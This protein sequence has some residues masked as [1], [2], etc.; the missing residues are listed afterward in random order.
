MA[1]LCKIISIPDYPIQIHQNGD[2]RV[3]VSPRKYIKL[4]R[5]NSVELMD[6]LDSIS[7]TPSIL[8]L[9]SRESFSFSKESSLSMVLKAFVDGHHS[10]LCIL[11]DHFDTQDY[12]V[13]DQAISR[14]NRIFIGSDEDLSW[15]RSQL[16]AADYVIIDYSKLSQTDSL[17]QLLEFENKEKG[18]KVIGI[19]NKQ[20][21]VKTAL[22]FQSRWDGYGILPSLSTEKIKCEQ[23]SNVDLPMEG[24]CIHSQEKPV[25]VPIYDAFYQLNDMNFNQIKTVKDQPIQLT[26]IDPMHPVAKYAVA[27]A[28]NDGHAVSCVLGDFPT[29]VTQVLKTDNLSSYVLIHAQNVQNAEG[30]LTVCHGDVLRNPAPEKLCIISPLT[31]SQWRYLGFLK[32]QNPTLSL[33]VL[34]HVMVPSTIKVQ[35]TMMINAEDRVTASDSLSLT[36]DKL[37]STPEFIASLC[38]SNHTIWIQGQHPH[39]ST[40]IATHIEED[41]Q[42]I[43]RCIIHPNDTLQDLLG[44]VVELDITMDVDVKT[45]AKANGKTSLQLP[46]KTRLVYQPS[47]WSQILQDPQATLIIE[48]LDHNPLLKTALEALCVTRSF[49]QNGCSV[50]VRARLI[51]LSEKK[52]DFFSGPCVSMNSN[53]D[54]V[55]RMSAL[56][57]SIR[58]CHQHEKTEAINE[59][60]NRDVM[61]EIHGASGTGKRETL[62]HCMEDY[63][64][65]TPY[66]QLR[67]ISCSPALDRQTVEETLLQWIHCQTPCTVVIDRYDVMALGYWR[68]LIPNQNREIYIQ[69]QIYQ[70]P[71]THRC[72]FVSQDHPS[73]T[74]SNHTLCRYIPTVTF[75]IYPDSEIVSCVR[76]LSED[77]VIVDWYLSIYTVCQ[78]ALNKPLSFLEISELW[79]WH[80]FYGQTMADETARVCALYNLLSLRYHQKDLCLLKQLLPVS[81][82]CWDYV[83]Q[84]STAQECTDRS[85]F[86]T[87]D[88]QKIRTILTAH[89]SPSLSDQPVKKHPIV[90]IQGEAGCGKDY[91]VDSVLK[92]LG[93]S[94]HRVKGSNLQAVLSS[95]KEA[96]A[97]NMI[98]VIEEADLMP[99]DMIE[100]LIDPLTDP[101]HFSIIATV[102][103]IHYDGRQPISNGILAQSLVIQCHP[104][105]D[106]DLRGML[107]QQFGHQL[108]V[109]Q[110]DELV[111]LYRAVSIPVSPRE[112]FRIVRDFL[113]ADQLTL[114]E[115][116]DQVIMTF[117][118]FRTPLSSYQKS[119][120]QVSEILKQKILA[121]QSLPRIQQA[122]IKLPSKLIGS[123]IGLSSR[124]IGG[125]SSDR[126]VPIHFFNIAPNGHQIA[127]PKQESLYAPHCQGYLCIEDPYFSDLIQSVEGECICQLPIPG[128][129]VPQKV[130]LSCQGQTETIA[131]V[132]LD[133]LGIPYVH[134]P[135]SLQGRPFF[136]GVT[137][138]AKQLTYTPSL[139]VPLTDDYSDYQLTLPSSMRECVMNPS[140]TLQEKLNELLTIFHKMSYDM[141]KGAA[142][143][144]R[145]LVGEEIVAKC[146]QEQ[147]GCCAEL[148]HAFAAVVGKYLKCPVR[149]VTGLCFKGR[150]QMGFHQWVEVLV[151]GHWVLMEPTPSGGG[152][153]SL[154]SSQTS[155]DQSDFMAFSTQILDQLNQ[156]KENQSVT[157]NSNQHDKI[158]QKLIDWCY[159]TGHVRAGVGVS[160]LPSSC[161]RGC[162]DLN[163]FQATHQKVYQQSHLQLGKPFPFIQVVVC[164]EDMEDPDKELYLKSL[165]DM[166]CPVYF[167]C[168]DSQR[169]QEVLSIEDIP[170]S[171]LLPKEKAVVIPETQSMVCLSELRHD[172]GIKKMEYLSMIMPDFRNRFNS[173]CKRNLI[174]IDLVPRDLDWL[175]QTVSDPSSSQCVSQIKRLSFPED[176]LIN[177]EYR[178]KLEQLMSCCVNV[179]EIEVPL[180]SNTCQQLSLMGPTF[181]KNVEGLQLSLGV[182]SVQE[183]SSFLS[184]FPSSLKELSIFNFRLGAE[185]IRA[186]CSRFS[187]LELLDCFRSD[188]RFDDVML[189]SHFFSLASKKLTVSGVQINPEAFSTIFKRLSS[190][191][192]ILD[193]SLSEIDSEGLQE[194]FRYLPNTLQSLNMSCNQIRVEDMRVL[195]QFFPSALEELNLDTTELSC[196]SLQLLGT[197]K[198]PRLKQLNLGG[199]KLGLRGM[200]VLTQDLLAGVEVLGL[201]RNDLESEGFNILCSKIN[202]QVIRQLNLG[203]NN[204]VAKDME[205]LA[206]MSMPVLESVFLY[207]NPIG[208][209]GEQIVRVALGDKVD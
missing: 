42:S 189:L 62:R 117:K 162:L 191:L 82:D 170:W 37:L 32:T 104:I 78:T 200:Q 166:R 131:T 136:L 126:Y 61:F 60:L 20:D 67:T 49:I 146:L 10:S 34:P 11:A 180:N 16:D 73:A 68:S 99:A 154:G 130:F 93:Q 163:V 47:R 187:S 203:G 2:S 175:I 84:I 95:V 113:H 21:H 79:H 129:T 157:K 156:H 7:L 118:Q 205:L 75:Q 144:Y 195:V 206:R 69:G 132:F 33:F 51:C 76:Q 85:S 123:G 55:K 39:L 12:Q 46:S 177:S 171:Q 173:Y 127:L 167:A 148:S 26:G 90:W 161:Q 30:T 56:S 9:D 105:S 64:M 58:V 128:G 201:G 133:Q 196:E 91:A 138:Q 14:A 86:L 114:K 106:T 3:L 109:G 152:M 112:I 147:R 151:N 101:P 24:V 54:W 122:A 149:L 63:A 169:L 135:K 165:F 94:Y 100:S 186:I 190:T 174:S 71:L 83:S 125:Q 50:P 52:P 164:R 193:V 182:V 188:L 207:N 110:I 202:F 81:S 66:H 119:F 25:I 43:H 142:D 53:S 137:Y 80:Q 103:G 208:V 115:C 143:L 178:V 89:L 141:S 183:F 197:I 192:Q 59:L 15:H 45:D 96:K 48:S 172:L 28:R 140:L 23:S 199:N 176:V 87:V 29:D 179:T 134:V 36:H 139:N 204:L 38:Q 5:D 35:A 97:K 168:A 160:A 116:W 198:S 27:L 19:L 22:S 102:N 124:I 92:E 8:P 145:N 74:P 41:H 40:E 44:E 6:D 4:E 111:N 17:N 181:F 153:S 31:D 185:G 88:Q 72:I 209:E 77:P 18:L 13:L 121:K 155:L 70:I 98:L 65:R 194:L 57:L 108:T 184:Y 1:F 120:D 150:S 159:A 107:D 158:M